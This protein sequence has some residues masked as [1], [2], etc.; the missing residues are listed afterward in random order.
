MEKR[1]MTFGGYNTAADGLWT[2]CEGWAFSDPVYEQNFIK[3]PGSSVTLDMSTALSDG[4]AAYDTRT[5]TATFESSE[6]GRLERKARIDLMVNQLDGRRLDIM[7]PDDPDR[8]LTGRISVKVLY[9]NMAH[10]S[11]AIEAICDPWK[12]ASTE[13]V[14]HIEGAEEE[15]KQTL[16]NTGRKPVVPTLLVEGGELA[17]TFEENTWTLSPGTY[18]LHEIY[19]ATGEHEVAYKGAGSVT[20]TWR[21][22]I[23]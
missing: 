3:I 1:S 23:L 21:E 8:Y 5:L 10:A 13:T 16:T 11:V 12:Y 19:M 14:V 22:A 18:I 20:M 7:L 4:E 9:N 17:L 6:G 2:L 15:Q